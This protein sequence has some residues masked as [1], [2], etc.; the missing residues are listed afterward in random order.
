MATVQTPSS[1]DLRTALLPVDLYEGDEALVLLASLPG[2]R[3][4]DLDI[5]LEADRLTLTAERHEPSPHGADETVATPLFRELG[6][7]R[8]TRQVRLRT[9]VD[10]DQVQ[11]KLEHGLLRLTLPKAPQARPRTI[12]VKAG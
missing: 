11:A 5:Q 10:A 2:V 7:V 4:E 3:A 6:G 8:W 12:Q 1:P 9:P